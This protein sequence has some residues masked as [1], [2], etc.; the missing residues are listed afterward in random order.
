MDSASSRADVV[1]HDPRGA[2]S[3]VGQGPPL[4]LEALGGGGGVGEGFRPYINSKIIIQ[5]VSTFL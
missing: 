5:T 3:G 1:P 4:P 2:P